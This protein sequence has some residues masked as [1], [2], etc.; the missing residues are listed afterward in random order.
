MPFALTPRLKSG[1]ILL[2]LCFTSFRTAVAQDL[3]NALTQLKENRRGF[4]ELITTI[5]LDTLLAQR[6]NRFSKSGIDSLLE[7]IRVSKSKP[8]EKLL[9]IN[10]IG[11]LLDEIRQRVD[12]Q[13]I[14][15]YDLPQALESFEQILRAIQDGVEY[16]SILEPLSEQRAK[17]LAH[18]FRD[19]GAQRL[20]D[21]SKFKKLA[22]RPEEALP[23]LEKEPSFPLGDSLIEFIAANHPERIAEHL[24][25]TRSTLTTRIRSH[26]NIYV[27]QIALL[28]N[29][30]ASG[31]LLP[32]V[33]QLA[34]KQVT[35]EKVFKFRTDSI[36][37]F[38]LL[39]DTRKREH[40]NTPEKNDFN[41]AILNEIKN[42][43]VKF[44]ARQL[45]EGHELSFD[46]RFGVVKELRMEDIYYVLATAGD[47]L[48]TSS[49]LGLYQK[50][51]SF[52]KRASADS[53]FRLVGYDRFRDFL[54]ISANY[55]TITDLF[56]TSSAEATRELLKN[57]ISRIE[58]E[59]YTSLEKAM[60][61]ADCFAGLSKDSLYGSV[62]REQLQ[63]NYDRCAASDLLLGARIYGILLRVFDHAQ[64]YKDPVKATGNRDGYNEK[65][66]RARLKNK[67][68][69]IIS[70][71]LFY[72]D[73]D[74]RT[75]YR[76][77]R[78]LFDDPAKWEVE[79]SKSWIRI[80]SLQ[81]QPLVYYVNLPLDHEKRL[82]L[83]AQDSLSRYLSNQGIEPS[84]LIHRGHS[85]HINHTMEM[86]TPDI[87]LAVLGACGGNNYVLDFAAVNPDVQLIF[88][89]KIGKTAINDS[90]IEELATTFLEKDKDVV[91]AEIWNR[92]EEKFNAD[93]AMLS[94]FREYIPPPHNIS[95]LFL[96][97]FNRDL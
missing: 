70:L 3:E 78:N 9:A 80:R 49:Y 68:G 23:Y 97:L 10:S 47:E 64:E 28:A 59:P 22:G 39:V 74:G 91:W 51:K 54:K 4:S 77:F 88:S 42:R 16:Q 90:I 75:S 94:H 40:G 63:S 86:M 55:N 5:N 43:S 45:N 7:E 38:Q 19:Y 48:Y 32:F 50:L 92:L 53:L 31:L 12:V 87:R 6:L 35:R 73:P 13:K 46:E 85:Y 79:E 67:K 36:G 33:V 61:V 83:M 1:I 27:R 52:L 69:E 18:V 81:G 71:V 89:K 95:I 30:T 2:L 15:W 44:F 41:N 26:S 17:F 62:I 65:L 57:Y 60:D 72:G 84:I 14:E 56:S 11:H 96:N 24:R 37:Y 29:D 20:N 8:S 34:K 25:T 93:P 66:Y 76:S 21:F 58:A 82:D